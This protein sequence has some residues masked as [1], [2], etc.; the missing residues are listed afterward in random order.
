VPEYVDVPQCAHCDEF[1]I[2]RRWYKF[3]SVEE[4]VREA[5]VRSVT[6][7]KGTR[8]E[9]VETGVSRQDSKNFFVEIDVK[10][11]YLDLTVDEHLDTVV[12]LKGGVCPRCSKIQGSYYESIIQVRTRGRKF[13]DEEKDHILEEIES[14]VDLLSRSSRDIFISKVEEMPGGFDVYLSSTSLGRSLSKDLADTYG[15]EG[16]SISYWRDRVQGNEIDRPVDS[17]IDEHRQRGP[18]VG[19]CRRE[20]EGRTGGGRSDREREGGPGPRSQ[21]LQASGDQE[22]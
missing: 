4:A 21:E 17:R 19:P 12:R 5:A 16:P 3:N 22:G 15:A 7:R 1:Q 2:E 10:V 18:E 9:G 14:K 8:V 6:S 11:K 20:R 13:P